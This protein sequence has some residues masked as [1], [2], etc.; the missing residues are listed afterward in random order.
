M[1]STPDSSRNPRRTLISDKEIDR[2]FAA[3]RSHGIDPSTCAIDIRMDGITF[4]PIATPSVA[5]NPYDA[6]KAGKD[7][8][9]DRRPRR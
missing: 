5:G 8:N 2:A 1:A 3:V 9:S 4:S 6:W 7:A